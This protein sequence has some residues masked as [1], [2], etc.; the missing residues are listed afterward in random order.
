MK[1]PTRKLLENPKDMEIS[2]V[3]TEPKTE[4]PPLIAQAQETSE[5]DSFAARRIPVGKGIPMMKAI[6]AMVAMATTI[7]RAVDAPKVIWMILGKAN[8]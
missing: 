3:N 4:A 1:V 7:R 5:F 2:T 8:P 6:G